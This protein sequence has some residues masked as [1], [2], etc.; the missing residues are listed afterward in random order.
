MWRLPPLSPNDMKSGSRCIRFLLYQ[1]QKDKATDTPQP[2]QDVDPELEEGREREERCR[3]ATLSAM[4]AAREVQGPS[5]DDD[6]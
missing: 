3:V 6:E 1:E 4:F 5:I 2:D